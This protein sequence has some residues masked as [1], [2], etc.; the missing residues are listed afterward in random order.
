MTNNNMYSI[1]HIGR[2]VKNINEE[3]KYYRSLG[4]KCAKSIKID[5]YQKV[6]VGLVDMGQG[7]FLELLGP[8]GKTSPI[9][10]FLA[11]GGGLHHICYQSKNLKDTMRELK[12][13]G[14]ILSRPTPS[15][16]DGKKVLFFY[17][18]QGEII[19][20]IEESKT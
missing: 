8:Y 5:H 15:V 16:F 18:R 19:E 10:N 6:K 17:S 7:I 1:H 2:V 9:K 12:K 4:F 3:L 20:F 14:T 13:H 11:K